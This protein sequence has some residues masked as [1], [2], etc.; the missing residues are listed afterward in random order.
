MMKPTL[1]CSAAMFMLGLAAPVH[2]QD[3]PTGAVSDGIQSSLNELFDD[4]AE[5]SL[6]SAYQEIVRQAWL[7][8]EDIRLW[9][10]TESEGGTQGLGVGGIPAIWWREEPSEGELYAQ[11]DWQNQ[12]T[13]MRITESGG[14]GELGVGNL[15][16]PSS[17]GRDGPITM[18][19]DAAGTVYVPTEEGRYIRASLPG[20]FGQMAGALDMNIDQ[21]IEAGVTGMLDR[22]GVYTAA[23]SASDVPGPIRDLL[24]AY[25][26]RAT[27]NRETGEWEVDNVTEEMLRDWVAEFRAQYES[28][29]TLP[30]LIHFAFILT[31]WTVRSQLRVREDTHINWRGRHVACND[32][33]QFTVTEGDQTGY[34]LIFDGYD[35]LVHLKDTDG[36]T[37]EYAYDKDVTVRI[38]G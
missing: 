35:R 19:F 16:L 3:D 30:P 23:T 15:V 18:Y 28:L 6:E 11:F 33:T 37:A 29:S 8:D 4:A 31:P 5:V 7:F 17:D 25:A 26:D 21:A 2:G 32:C 24:A 27:F 34:V 1:F 9:M 12:A 13:S 38:P 22:L 10:N 36:S 14:G 20:L